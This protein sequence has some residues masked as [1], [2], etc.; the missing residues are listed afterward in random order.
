MGLNHIDARLEVHCNYGVL[1]PDLDPQFGGTPN[2]GYPGY[3]VY[4]IRPHIPYTASTVY[5]IRGMGIPHLGCI[6]I[7]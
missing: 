7:P 1:D 4:G 3:G 5:G 2:P 6:G